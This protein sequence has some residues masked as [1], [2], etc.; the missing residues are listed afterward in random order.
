MKI[1]AKRGRKYKSKLE[2]RVAARL[3]G[4]KLPYEYETAYLPYVMEKTYNPDFYDESSG[5]YLEVKGVLD[6]QA[7]SKMKHVR[8]QHPEKDI[9]IIFAKAHNKCPGIKMT[10]A[11]WA[12]KNGFP[13]MEAESFK[14][15]DVK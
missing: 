3:Q 1:N 14:S 8:E 15:K 2:S 13:W 7:R 10:H 11:E 4:M 9:R 12:D 5:I 6:Q